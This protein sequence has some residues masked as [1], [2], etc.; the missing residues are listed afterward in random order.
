ML[1]ILPKTHQPVCFEDFMTKP[2]VGTA[3]SRHF[4]ADTTADLEG[5]LDGLGSIAETHREATPSPTQ[6]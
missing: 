2:A 4:S 3:F 1:T 6:L 5:F